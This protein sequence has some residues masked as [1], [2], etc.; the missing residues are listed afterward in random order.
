MFPL[1]QASPRPA[2]FKYPT[3]DLNSPATL[4]ARQSPA[5]QTAA[6]HAAAPI[7]LV[8]AR[9]LFGEM[10]MLPMPPIPS[11]GDPRYY[12]ED[13]AQEDFLPGMMNENNHAYD[14]NDYNVGDDEK[15]PATAID[16]I[17]IDNEPV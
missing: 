12:E 6:A 9:N 5:A 16:V 2:Q 14:E 15:I 3:L 17:N 10:P 1:P 4:L 7:V 13:Y 11:P 8:P